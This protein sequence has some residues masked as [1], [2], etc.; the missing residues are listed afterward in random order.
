MAVQN[1]QNDVFDEMTDTDMEEMIII[2]GEDEKGTDKKKV[3]EV[4]GSL[5]KFFKEEESS[6]VTYEKI[7][8]NG[9]KI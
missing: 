2:D 5:E 8:R 6:Y 1:E 9:K 7:P 3:K 4:M